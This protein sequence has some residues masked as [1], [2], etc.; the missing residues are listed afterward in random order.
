MTAKSHQEGKRNISNVN[1]ELLEHLLETRDTV[2]FQTNSED[3]DENEIINY[4]GQWL[5]NM[6]HGM[7]TAIMKDGSKYSG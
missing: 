5:G 2:I 1:I 6:K 7:G 3:S 4:K